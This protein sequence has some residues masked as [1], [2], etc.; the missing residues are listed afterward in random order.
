VRV[1][2]LPLDDDERETLVGHL[3]RVRVPELVL[4]PTSARAL[5]LLRRHEERMIDMT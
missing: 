3:D 1:P 2:Q 5:G 4:V